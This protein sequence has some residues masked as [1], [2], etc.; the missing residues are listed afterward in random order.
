MNDKLISGC[1]TAGIRKL[2]LKPKTPGLTNKT[3]GN[4]DSEKY[5]CKSE[6]GMR[7]V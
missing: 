1:D 4:G 5:G 7:Y 6:D 3:V 2:L